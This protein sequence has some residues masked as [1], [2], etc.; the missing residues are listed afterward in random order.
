MKTIF[1]N[2]SVFLRFRMH[3]GA[4]QQQLAALAKAT[5]ADAV[6]AFNRQHFRRLGALVYDL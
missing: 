4:R 2:G 5:G 1:P 6:A 3:D